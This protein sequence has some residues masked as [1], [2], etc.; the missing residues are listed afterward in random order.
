MKLSIMLSV[1]S[2]QNVA[3]TTATKKTN[4][5]KVLITSEICIGKGCVLESWHLFMHGFF[6]FDAC[7]SPKAAET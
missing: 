7:C 3:S 1:L 6:P 2:L 5:S 4:P